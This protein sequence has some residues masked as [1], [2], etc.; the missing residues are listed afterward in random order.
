MRQAMPEAT[1]LYSVTAVVVV[2]LVVWVAVILKMAKEPWARPRLSLS[3]ALTPA[4]EMGA[5]DE[6]EATSGEDKPSDD[7]RAS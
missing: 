2:A 3:A 1:V 5:G 4:G 6:A 7:E